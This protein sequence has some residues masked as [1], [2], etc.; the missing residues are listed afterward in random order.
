M[1]FSAGE[2][3]HVSG[4]IRIKVCFFEVRPS[5]LFLTKKKKKKINKLMS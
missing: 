3:I 2:K 4:V 1:K 5:K